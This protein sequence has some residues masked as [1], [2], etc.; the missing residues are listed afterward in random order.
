MRCISMTR[1]LAR[2]VRD[3]LLP[4][5]PPRCVWPS[6]AA[7]QRGGRGGAAAGC[8]Q[9]RV[10]MVR[11]AGAQHAHP[12]TAGHAGRIH[13]RHEGARAHARRRFPRTRLERSLGRGV[14]QGRGR[15]P[16]RSTDTV[17]I[18]VT[19]NAKMNPG[20]G[21]PG[22]RA[23]CEDLRDQRASARRVGG[24]ATS[25]AQS[26]RNRRSGPYQELS[27]IMKR[28]PAASVVPFPRSIS[29]SPMGSATPF[30]TA[31]YPTRLEM[32]APLATAPSTAKA[33]G[34]R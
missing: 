3:R 9:Y 8:R 33:I 15:L 21:Q 28:R 1:D 11:A 2:G 12:N 27:A 23:R 18:L 14:D 7:F 16:P 26:C 5:S 13:R 25:R 32:S 20:H 17:H 34:G 19:L 29:D 4:R 6:G 31:Q 22:R 30:S 10:H 24:I